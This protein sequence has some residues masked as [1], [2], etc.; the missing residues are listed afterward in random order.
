MFKYS[1]E[2]K[3]FPQQVKHLTH[4]ATN[5]NLSLCLYRYVEREGV[6]L[7]KEKEYQDCGSPRT[8]SDKLYGD[9][10]NR[11]KA[12][13]GAAYLTQRGSFKIFQTA[14]FI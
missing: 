6:P 7:A 9:Q 11:L 2:T 3:F 8:P 13:R 14:K 1:R 5:L 12:G 4:V 10:S